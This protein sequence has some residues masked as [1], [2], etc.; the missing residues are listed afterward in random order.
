MIVDSDLICHPPHSIQQYPIFTLP[1]GAKAE[2]T[3]ERG[4]HRV[5]MGVEDAG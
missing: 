4:L 5:G 1:T 2:V 3:T